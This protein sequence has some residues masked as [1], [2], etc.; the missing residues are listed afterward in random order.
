MPPNRS[1]QT[2]SP[3][4]VG[5]Y[6]LT[7]ILYP[8][9]SFCNSLALQPKYLSNSVQNFLLWFLCLIWHLPFAIQ[10]FCGTFLGPIVFALDWKIVNLFG[11]LPAFSGLFFHLIRPSFPPSESF[12]LRVTFTA[13][14]FMLYFFAS[15]IHNS[16]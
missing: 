10:D 11:I 8:F 5:L 14:W 2:I 15:R 7:L 1:W 9:S 4:A 12:I 16:L 6:A 13:L 3:S